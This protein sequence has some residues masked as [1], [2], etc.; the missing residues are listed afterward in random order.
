MRID[1]HQHF[2]R[3]DPREYA[4]ISDEMATLQR[5][6][7]P[8]DL[9]PALASVGFHGAV[10]VQARQSLEETRW[11]LELASQHK[12]I[13]AVV[14]WVD[15]RSPDL[16]SQLERLAQ[17]PKLAGVRHVVQDEAD[18]EFMLRPEFRR[19]IARLR[20]F[21]LTYDL[22]LY[23]R[24][25][26]IAIK[27]VEAFQD[28]PFVLDHIAKPRIADGLLSPWSEGI[29]ALGSFPNVYCKLS[30]MLTEARWR[31]WQPDDFR[32]Y[33]DAV[34]EAFGIDRLMIGSDWPV[35]LLSGEYGQAM[36][37]VIDYLR[38]LPA[39]GQAGVLGENCARFYS[40]ERGIDHPAAP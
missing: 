9:E 35:C 8:K 14:G 38:H 17:H 37:I 33:L 18:D 11:L 25:L 22:L 3:Y 10:A 23:P 7:L 2:W 21:N 16:P 12:F 30:G 5:D 6:F 1:S 28:Q 31:Q 20:D 15:L 27:L 26:S 32:P 4:W 34:F 39:E 36:H 24:H 19:G 13:Q 29:R 40:I